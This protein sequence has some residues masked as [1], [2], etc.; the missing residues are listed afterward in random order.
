MS[1]I[2]LEY[3]DTCTTRCATEK[4]IRVVPS[5]SLPPF[6]SLPLSTSWSSLYQWMLVWRRRHASLSFQRAVTPTRLT[7]TKPTYMLHRQ[8]L[9]TSL[10][11][12]HPRAFRHPLP[13]LYV[14]LAPSFTH[15]HTKHIPEL[16]RGLSCVCVPVR[17]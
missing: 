7:S 12:V 1:S 14:S 15:S 13:P 9:V 8:S 16:S 4:G 11:T 2:I 6:L 5:S 17:M 3:G 10:E